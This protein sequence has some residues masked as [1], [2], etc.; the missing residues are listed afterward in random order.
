MTFDTAQAALIV[1]ALLETANN[2]CAHCCKEFGIQSPPQTSHGICR[3]HF[4]YMMREAGI[5]E[6]VQQREMAKA[7]ARNLYSPDMA[8]QGAPQQS[9]GPQTSP[10]SALPA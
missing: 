1:N 7:D 9:A 6:D 3:R 8:T 5:P 10:H 4:L 2:P